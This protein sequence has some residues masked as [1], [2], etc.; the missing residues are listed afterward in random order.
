MYPGVAL[1]PG[2]HAVLGGQNLAVARMSAHPLAAQ[3]L[4]QFLTSDPMQRL[5]AER[6]GFAPTRTAVY[7]EPAVQQH[8]PYVKTLLK[9]VTDAY[10]RPVTPYYPKFSAVFRDGICSAMNHD[11]QV[12]DNLGG[13]LNDALAGHDPPLTSSC[14]SG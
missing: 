12:P 1:V 7:Q 10:L 9:A 3:A 4:I 13:R 6:G 11:G 2:G 8:V 14:Q 5:L